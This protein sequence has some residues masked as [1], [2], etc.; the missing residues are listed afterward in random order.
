M[1]NWTITATT[2]YCDSV[3]DEV[4]LIAN[5]DGIVQCTGYSRYSKPTGETARLMKIKNRQAGKQLACEGLECSRVT[6]YRNKLLTEEGEDTGRSTNG[7]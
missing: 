4:T 1:A 5:R 7:E 6:K 3:D 2:I